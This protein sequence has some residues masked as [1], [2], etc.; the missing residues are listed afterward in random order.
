MK[1]K[2][3]TCEVCGQSISSGGAA[4]TAH[5]RKHVREGEMEEV[6]KGNKLEFVRIGIHREYVEPV[7]RQP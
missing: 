3:I 5:M 2:E 1:Y 6:K 4:R 7:L